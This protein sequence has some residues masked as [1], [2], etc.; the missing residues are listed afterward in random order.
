MIHITDWRCSP[1]PILQEGA[2]EASQPSG[3]VLDD[4]KGVQPWKDFGEKAKVKTEGCCSSKEICLPK[5][6]QSGFQSSHPR[7]NQYG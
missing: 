2:T 1:T 7:K 4:F 3:A 5:G 6:K